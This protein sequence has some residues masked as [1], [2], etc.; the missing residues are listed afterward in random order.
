MK[1]VSVF[2]GL[3]LCLNFGFGQN[4][5]KNYFPKSIYTN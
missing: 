2:L 4:T 5:L 3:T 1:K